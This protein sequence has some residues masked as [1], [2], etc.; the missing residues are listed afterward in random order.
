MQN[1]N[2]K[3]IIGANLKFSEIFQIDCVFVEYDHLI[4]Q[5]LYTIEYIWIFV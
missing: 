1:Q 3:I 2:F 4:L 5:L